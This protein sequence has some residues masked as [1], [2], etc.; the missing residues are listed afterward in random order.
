MTVET[1]ESVRS[2]QSRT[3]IVAERG[4]YVLKKIGS[5][6]NDRAKHRT[7]MIINHRNAG[8]IRD[9]L[10]KLAESSAGW[11][12]NYS[13]ASHWMHTMV[14]LEVSLGELADNWI[15]TIALTGGRIPEIA[16]LTGR[17]G[18][19]AQGLEGKA[20]IRKS[21]LNALVNL[22]LLP[23]YRGQIVTPKG[24]RLPRG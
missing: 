4:Y 23:K 21:L 1:P 15:K 2:E 7:G 11:E 18:F 19:I 16:P 12:R 10:S 8:R 22:D 14:I 24:F 6:T 20:V 13:D 5:Q 17:E 9:E 3:V